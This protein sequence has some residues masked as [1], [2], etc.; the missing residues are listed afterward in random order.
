MQPERTSSKPH[1]AAPAHVY[2][3]HSSWCRSNSGGRC[4]CEPRWQAKVWDRLAERHLTKTFSSKQEAREWVDETRVNLRH[5]KA[6][7]HHNNLT[8]GE[9]G[10]VVLD[11]A[12]AGIVLGRGG[13]RLRP[14]TI[15]GYKRNWFKRTRAWFGKLKLNEISRP[16]IEDF[17]L[18]CRKEGLAPATIN[19]Q[20]M[21]LSLVLRQALARGLIS[22]F[23]MDRMGIGRKPRNP[24]VAYPIEEIDA[25]IEALSG[26]PRTVATLIAD[27]GV[28]ISEAIALKWKNINFD[29]GT[30]TVEAEW[31]RNTHD[32]IDPKTR[33]GKRTIFMTTRLRQELLSYYEDCLEPSDDQW[34]FPSSV[35]PARPFSATNVRTR[36]Q[37]AWAQAGLSPINPHAMRH[38]LATELAAHNVH[39]RT[40]AD[41]LGHEDPGFT[42]RRY[43]HPS[44]T[45]M[46]SAMESLERDPG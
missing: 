19:E 14:R 18:E 31:C 30:L 16:D 13:T 29:R 35:D 43:T 25:R 41:I 34:L 5:G 32:L 20:L 40:M 21:P 10:D 42:L 46:K 37:R 23:P 39:P 27:S 24:P 7:A 26:W 2:E 22:Y 45:A 17:V 9:F 3:R 33:A 38:S 15:E 12:E 44:P 11:E 6:Q 1:G 4:N 28:R 36:M 8:V